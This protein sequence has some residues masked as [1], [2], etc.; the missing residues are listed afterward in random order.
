MQEDTRGWRRTKTKN[1]ILSAGP[2]RVSVHVKPHRAGASDD[3]AM[4][5][6]AFDRR[7]Q[8]KKESGIS[9]SSIELVRFPEAHERA[10]VAV[11]G[12]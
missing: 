4:T 10:E 11:Q 2:Q 1:C 7:A 9:N 3:D 8:H 12:S 5:F 6:H